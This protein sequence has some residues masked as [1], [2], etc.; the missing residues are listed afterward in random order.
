MPT[1]N[2]L[3]DLMKPE[4][5]ATMERWVEERKHPKHKQEIPIPF[6]I[7]AQ[8]GY[9]YGWQAVVDYRRGYS[10][11]Y[12]EDGSLTGCLKKVRNAFELQDAVALIEAAR[13]VHYL[14]K[15]DEGKITAA[16]IAS[17]QDRKN[18][19]TTIQQVQEFVNKL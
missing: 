18:A 1:M 12:E 5:R 11:G 4:D 2:N 10:I 8:L 13:K 6:F 15:L 17:C 7:C 14:A 16:N 9:Y 3:M 19:N